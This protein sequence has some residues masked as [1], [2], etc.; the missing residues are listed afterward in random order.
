MGTGPQEP[1]LPGLHTCLWLQKLTQLLI[2]TPQRLCHHQRPMEGPSPSS[3]SAIPT[4]KMI[5]SPVVSV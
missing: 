3:Q 2:P 5:L 4:C 1:K